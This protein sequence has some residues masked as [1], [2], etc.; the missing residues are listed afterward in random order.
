MARR[1]GRG[2]SGRWPS[3]RALRGRRLWRQRDSE[4][5]ATLNW[6]IFNEPSGGVQAAAEECSDASNGAIRHQVPVPALAGRRAARA[7]RPPPRREGRLARPPRPRRRLDRRVRQRRLDRAGAGRRAAGGHARTCSPASLEHRAVRGQALRRP[8]LV[9]HAAALVPQGPRP[10]GAQDVGRDARRWPRRSARKGQIQV[11]GNKYEGLVVWVNA[12]DRR[13]RAPRSSPGRDK[14][15]LDEAKTEKA[16]AA[17][18]K[19]APSPVAPPNIDTS[20]GGHGA[21]GLR[22]RH[23]RLHDQLPVRLPVGEGQRARTSS[24]RSRRRKYPRS[25]RTC[26]ASRRSA[27]STSRSRR[28]PST[29]PRRSRPS[30]ASSS[31]RTSWRSPRPAACRPCARDV[32]DNPEINKTAIRASP[33]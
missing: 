32:Y 9:E 7:A 26:R 33:T 27:A 6:F 18:G 17:M 3:W 4:G 31:R 8:D 12:H 30:S 25:T 23:A 15:A 29:R 10:A 16:L 21:P 22:V 11:Q 20:T 5:R 13:R 19:F 14:I 2:S 28:T 1:H 24:S